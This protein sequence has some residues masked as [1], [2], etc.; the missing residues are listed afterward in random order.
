M[1]RLRGHNHSATLQRS[2]II[3]VPS[4]Q[5]LG[6]MPN[7]KNGT[8]VDGT[9]LSDEARARIP[10]ICRRFDSLVFGYFPPET[11]IQSNL[12]TALVI[13]LNGIQVRVSVFLGLNSGA[14]LF[15]TAYNTA[16]NECEFLMISVGS[17]I[18]PD[19]ITHIFGSKMLSDTDISEL[20]ELL[21]GYLP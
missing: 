15:L 17:T 2:A 7:P 18:V 3:C 20:L 8:V 13:P 4:L 11:G 6:L 12:Q 1:K 16:L 14:E 9:K 5:V 21:D 10:K 19:G